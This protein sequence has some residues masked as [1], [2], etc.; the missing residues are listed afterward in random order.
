M[1]PIDKTKLDTFEL[2]IIFILMEPEID[3]SLTGCIDDLVLTGEIDEL[4]LVLSMADHD[5]F[6]STN[7]EAHEEA[8]R[9]LLLRIQELKNCGPDQFRKY[10]CDG[11]NV[12]FMLERYGVAIVPSIL[13]EKECDDMVN[14]MWDFLEHITADMEVPIRRDD[15]RSWLSFYDLFVIHSMLMQHWQVGHAQFVWILRQNPKI[16][17][18]FARIW[19]VEREDLIVSFDGAA[20][21][22]PSEVTNRGYFRGKEWLHCD[23]NFNN[24][25]FICVQSWVTGL[26]V[27]PGD[28]TLTFLEGSNRLH[29]DFAGAFELNVKD[30]WYKLTESEIQWYYNRGCRNMTITCPPGSL[31][32]WDSRT[33]H[34]GKEALKDRQLRNFRCVVYLCYTPRSLITE[35]NRKKKVKAL[36]EMRMTSHWPHKVKLF[37]TQPRTYGKELPKLRS[38][39]PPVLNLLGL[40]LA[41]HK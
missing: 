25:N 41:G 28:A 14:G 29:G 15:E 35:A 22:M 31:V 20:F 4:E 37:A 27:R 17:D 19:G 5:D 21:H 7:I 18:I 36:D 26:E 10:A 39:E 2:K 23:Q 12:T 24:S 16:V 34:A 1:S 13:D 6:K 33:I 30:D 40:R 11:E 32:L 8:K 9:R 38:L 3:C